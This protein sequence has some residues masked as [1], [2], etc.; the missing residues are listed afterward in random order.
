ME[1][2]TEMSAPILAEMEDFPNVTEII[3]LIG[4]HNTKEFE[5][6]WK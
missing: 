6:E 3:D 4:L 5:F 1:R 2:V